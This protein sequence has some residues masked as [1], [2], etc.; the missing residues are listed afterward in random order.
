MHVNTV[1]C[2][3]FA[4]VI[5]ILGTQFT[6]CDEHV[7]NIRIREKNKYKNKYRTPDME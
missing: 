2:N 5:R 1:K 4:L 6:E 3:F 7:G